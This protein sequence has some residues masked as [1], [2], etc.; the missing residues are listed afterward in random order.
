MCVVSIHLLTRAL[1]ILEWILDPAAYSSVLWRRM[2]QQLQP[3]SHHRR[4]AQLELATS[5]SPKLACLEL[6]AARLL[7]GGMSGDN[8]IILLSPDFQFFFE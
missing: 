6:T 2:I 4:Y 5:V 3:G 7:R 8:T 1:T